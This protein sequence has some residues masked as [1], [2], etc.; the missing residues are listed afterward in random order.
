MRGD[1]LVRKVEMEGQDHEGGLF[2]GQTATGEGEAFE[3]GSYSVHIE[4]PDHPDI[5]TSM[6]TVFQVLPEAPAQG[7]R[8]LVFLN[9]PRLRR[10]ARDGG[11]GYYREEQARAL[12]ERLSG[13]VERRTILEET[14]LW[15][16]FGWFAAII[17]LLTVEWIVR[18]RTGML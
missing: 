7:E 14:A 11:G 8:A 5:P 1:E 6:S 4:T 2:Q 9:E 17:G 10:L 3:P 12:V 18:K 13:T 16:H 15:R